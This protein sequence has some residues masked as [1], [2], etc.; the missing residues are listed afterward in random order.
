MK[1][2]YNKKE[3]S[4]QDKETLLRESEILNEKHPD[5]IPILIQIDSNILKMDKY[6]FLVANDVTVSYYFEVLKC[7]LTD[8]SPT[9]IL[10]ISVARF[11][12]NGSRELTNIKSDSKSLKDF[13]EQYKDES[14]GMLIL[15][16]SRTTIFKWVKS[17]ASYYL[18]I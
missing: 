4:Q 13:F 1:I 3:L 15:S 11:K 6:K 12:K 17:T 8:L 2:D 5:K 16:V 10:V 9:D 7:K 14:T 18:G